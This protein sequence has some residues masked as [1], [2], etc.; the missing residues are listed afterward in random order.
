MLKNI[1]LVTLH[2]LRTIGVFALLRKL[3]RNQVRIICY[4]GGQ[5]GDEGRYNPLLFGS[6]RLIVDRLDWLVNK[7]FSPCGIEFLTKSPSP[8]T[9]PDKKL[10]V[11]VT[12][13]DGWFSTIS[14]VIEVC[15]SR[16]FPVCVYL[17][18]RQFES[19]LPVVAVVMGY[20]LWRRKCN[21]VDFRTLG[22]LAEMLDRKSFNLEL[23][24]GRADFLRVTTEYAAQLPQNRAVVVSYLE[25]L[26]SALGV[27]PSELDLESRRFDYM[28]EN[29]LKEQSDLGCVFQLH[30]DVHHYPIGDPLALEHDIR[31][32]QTV[33]QRFGMVGPWHY[34]YPSGSFDHNA[35]SVLPRNNVH[36]ATTCIPGLIDL[37]KRQSM[38]Y[39]PRFLDG[40]NVSQ[41]EFEAEM[42]GVMSV[43]RGLARF[44]GV[45]SSNPLLSE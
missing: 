23:P 5:I 15:R 1:K 13:D 36:S 4:H 10:P 34:C 16:K 45:R 18:T 44:S 42:S 11:I 24:S 8:S 2:L 35:Q 22:V 41:I 27:M 26:G 37:S 21:F 7:G 20:L 19:N 29:E 12:A 30:G 3:T 9:L 32:C 43:F 31:A 17:S 14:S 38:M 40:E 6:S 25:S 39:L 28:N 33:L